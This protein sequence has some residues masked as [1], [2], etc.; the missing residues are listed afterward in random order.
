MAYYAVQLLRL[1]FDI[2]S[3]YSW[4]KL[5]GTLDERKWVTRIIFLE[6]IAGVPGKGEG[7]EE[8]IAGVP[9]KGEGGENV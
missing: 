6:T 7:G 3:G 5:V 1:N 2:F 4:G 9:G 8:T